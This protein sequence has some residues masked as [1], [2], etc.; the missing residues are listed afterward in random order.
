LPKQKLDSVTPILH[1]FYWLRKQQRA[2]FKVAVLTFQCLH[3]LAPPYLTECVE[4]MSDLPSRRRL[5]SSWIADLV[6]PSTR[7]STVGD[8]VYR[9][10]PPE[11]AW[12]SLPTSVPSILTPS[13]Q[14]FRQRLNT[15]LFHSATESS[16]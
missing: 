16:A 11:P 10:P 14:V 3:G 13:L 1:D 5:R 15:E 9:S 6:V 12:N 2:Q 8:R 7:L 4:H